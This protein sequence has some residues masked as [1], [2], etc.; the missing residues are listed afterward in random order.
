[1]WVCFKVNG[2]GRHERPPSFSEHQVLKVSNKACRFIWNRSWTKLVN[3]RETFGTS[4]AIVITKHCSYGLVV[5]NCRQWLHLYCSHSIT[6]PSGHCCFCCHSS[7]ER[8]LFCRLQ[9][10]FERSNLPYSNCSSK[11]SEYSD[12]QL[13]VPMRPIRSQRKIDLSKRDTQK[14][15]VLWRV[16]KH[17]IPLDYDTLYICLWCKFL[18]DKLLF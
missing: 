12:C 13:G 17:F 5:Q 16:L 7:E 15:A 9:S 3:L 1:M 8:I 18:K 14:S 4:L 10:W 6:N 2:K 11:D